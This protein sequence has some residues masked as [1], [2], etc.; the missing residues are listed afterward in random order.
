MTK[1]EHEYN[2]IYPMYELKDYTPIKCARLKNWDKC[3]YADGQ[4]I[5]KS[6][7]LSVKEIDHGHELLVKNWLVEKNNLD[8]YGYELFIKRL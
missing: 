1:E 7:V 6:Q 5:P 2:V 8:S 3:Y 4:Q